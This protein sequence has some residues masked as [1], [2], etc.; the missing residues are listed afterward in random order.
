MPSLYPQTEKQSAD[1][2]NNYT[3]PE[4]S[5]IIGISEDFNLTPSDIEH[6]SKSFLDEKT[7]RLGGIRR[8]SDDVG[9]QILDITTRKK[10]VNYDGLAIPYFNVWN[11]NQVIEYNLRRDKPD[12]EKNQNGELKEKRK[13]VKPRS[14]KNLLYIPPMI[15]AEWL[16]AK[17]KKLI[18]IVEGEFKA[19]ALARIA[20][21]NWTSDKWHFLPLAI[22]GVDNFKTKAKVIKA[23]G[24]KVTASVGLPEFEKIEWK[25]AKVII[26]F[27]SDIEDKPNVKAARYRINRFFRDKKIK[28]FNL[29]FPKEI[30][31]IQTKGID[32]YLG[33]IELSFD[34]NTAIDAALE[35]IETA[36]KPK[37]AKT[38]V[39]DNF[40]L[41]ED[42]EG[43]K[44]GVYYT[45][46][47]GESLRVCSPL[48]IVAETQ[49][50][51]GENYGRLLEWK[52]SQN[53]L[54]RWAMP[55]ELIHSQGADLA[56]YLASSGLEIMPSRKHHE[57][58]AFYIA[59][60]NAEKVIVSTDKIGWH[61][62]C[63]VLP[64]ETFGESENEIVYQ[65]EYEG[66]HNFK[67]AG[68]LAEWQENI[69]IYCKNN[70][71]LLFA[72]S[73]AFAAPLLQI[74]GTGGG[75]FHFRGSTSTGKTTASLVGGSVWGGDG[76][77]GF[78]QTWKA[79][80]NGLEIVAAGHNHALLCLDEI[81]ECEAR[82]VGNVAY[83]LANGRGKV[84]MTKTLQARHSLTWNLLFLSTGE[85][86]LADKITESG[87]TI[88]GGQEIRL[89]DIEADT[90]NF[91]LF[92]DVCGFPGGQSFSDH[93]RFASC[94]YYGTAI[95]EFLVWLTETDLEDIREKWRG[96][97]ISFIDDVL[98][99]KEKVPSEVLRVAS[100]FALVALGGELATEADITKWQV[101]EAYE[102]AKTVFL[103]W[104]DGREG[105]GKS[106]VERGIRRVSDF[107]NAN[108]IRFYNQTPPLNVNGT[109]IY[110][111][112]RVPNAAGYIRKNVFDE[113]EYL[114]FPT[115]FKTE[116]CKGLDFRKIQA[117]LL[118][119]DC[120]LGDTA[121]KF[122]TN[123]KIDGTQK[124]CYVITQKI[125]EIADEKENEDQ[126]TKTANI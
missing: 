70:S 71:R 35:L 75:G 39:A 89:C 22:S 72:V 93:L 25:G 53:R 36:Q 43:E 126:N 98:P 115:V 12:Y 69:S 101:G 100:R 113:I 7:L 2:E 96:F 8:V 47:N 13:Y 54:H 84:R 49:T 60:S 79:T 85:Q 83:M 50:E 28:T 16:E 88:K 52:D 42:G 102:A 66:H 40:T 31:G 114:I 109:S 9:H 5:S 62:E 37:K 57:K 110:E 105:K 46:E 81:G 61:K 55:I 21:D 104:M 73:V 116:I 112:Q 107:L 3:E 18:V 76:E 20:S 124:R 1:I 111:N 78:L 33:A 94:Q 125:F 86:S 10:G 91:G 45:D 103:Q 27:D 90:G 122:T 123:C 82:E 97:K 121:G 74:T 15:K 87:G 30:D 118:E 65:T 95:R 14:T 64:D 108:Q 23:S 32:D 99:N 120:L 6:R 80:A 29:D 51:T 56:K 58:L 63:F 48:K 4:I 77:H 11:D 17:S 119:K 26:C 34:A 106:D 44:P 19:L 67:T 38:P 59:T 41:I 92:E 68:T 117:A 24:E